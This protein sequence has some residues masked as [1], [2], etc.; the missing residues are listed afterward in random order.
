MRGMW[1]LI[2]D[3]GVIPMMF[4]LVFG[5]LALGASFY[6]ALRPRSAA[7]SRGFIKSMAQATLFGTL[8]ATFADVG[9]TLYTA[10]HSWEHGG[11]VHAA[12][13]LVEGLAE[14]MSPGIVGFSFLA[15]TAMLTAVGSRRLDEGSEVR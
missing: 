6:F 11:P 15:L 5:L 4:I 12:H 13:L 14:S 1:T 10:S 2:R 3:G 8:A 7:R 9:A